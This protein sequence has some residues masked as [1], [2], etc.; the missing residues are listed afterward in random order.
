MPKEK[1]QGSKDRKNNEFYTLLEDIENEVSK[2]WTQLEGKKIWCNC[3]DP[4]WSNFN[5]Y[6]EAQ[7]KFH[8]FEVKYTCYNLVPQNKNG[9]TKK[10]VEETLFDRTDDDKII[11][12]NE[13]WVDK[14]GFCEGDFRSPTQDKLWEWADV[15]ITNP[16]FSLFREFVNKIIEREKEF[17]IIGPQN[18]ITYKDTFKYIAD[19]KIWLGY[20]YHLTGFIKINELGK[21]EFL[22]AKKPNGS[23]PR[24]CTWYTNLDTSIR[25]KPMILTDF[26]IDKFIKY[27]NY[28]AYETVWFYG[29]PRNGKAEYPYTKKFLGVPITFLQKYCPEQFKI[30]DLCNGTPKLNPDFWGFN[31]WCSIKGKYTYARIFVKLTNDYYNKLKG[32]YK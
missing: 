12:T 20:N 31:G 14:Y 6:F 13:I 32:V 4:E 17:L 29:K 3:D 1:F 21:K 25:H 28:D 26:D 19:N 9:Y 24:C 15:I 27:D 30:Y 8:K 7:K 18:A 10:E 5:K 23:V 16:P 11:N 2:Y 22:D